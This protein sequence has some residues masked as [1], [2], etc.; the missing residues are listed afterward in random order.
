MFPA[1][2]PVKPP[3]FAAPLAHPF[4]TLAVLF[5]GSLVRRR[6]YPGVPTVNQP[7]PCAT[8]PLFQVR[9]VRRSPSHAGAH[10]AISVPYPPPHARTAVGRC[11]VVAGVVAVGVWI[12]IRRR[13]GTA[14][15][16]T[17]SK[18]A[19]ERA[20]TPTPST[21]PTAMPLRLRRARCCHCGCGDSRC[22]NQSRQNLPHDS[23][24]DSV[25]SLQNSN[26]PQRA[27]VPIFW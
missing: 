1:G 2:A 23:H 12:G 26:R 24:L 22:R 19:D 4:A 15:Q 25:G 13:Q 17:S 3:I 6:R 18:S 11:R 10:P 9:K 5:G 21:V 27:K 16:G 20:G 8:P 14:D 7:S